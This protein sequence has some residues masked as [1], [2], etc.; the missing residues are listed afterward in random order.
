MGF[1]FFDHFQD[2]DLYTVLNTIGLDHQVSVFID[3]EISVTPTVNLVAFQC[4]FFGPSGFS[5]HDAP[6]N[7]KIS[8]MTLA[9]NTSLFPVGSISGESSTT[10]APT[11][12]LSLRIFIKEMNE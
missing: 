1:D 5:C 2:G 4:I 7:N 12:C 11:R 3:A 6:N 8:R 9:A 10:S